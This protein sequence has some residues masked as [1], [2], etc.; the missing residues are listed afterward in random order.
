[1]TN[2]DMVYN[3]K[4]LIVIIMRD[5]F[6]SAFCGRKGCVF[7]KL[8]SVILGFAVSVLITATV[9]V[10]VAAMMYFTDLSESAGNVCVYVGTAAGVVCGAYVAARA[11]ERRVLFHSLAV[12]VMFVFALVGVAVG[13]NGGVAVNG[14]F[15]AV[16][17]GTMAAAVAGAVAG[18]R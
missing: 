16:I 2:S 4:S 8:R 14:H 1:M 17:A 18:N 15:A 5:F 6:M 3:A 13:V 11:A 7:M 9:I 10:G 12:A